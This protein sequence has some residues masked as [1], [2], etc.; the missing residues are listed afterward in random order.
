MLKFCIFYFQMLCIALNTDACVCVCCST[1]TFNPNS[2]IFAFCFKLS[3]FMFIYPCVVIFFPHS[4]PLISLISTLTNAYLTLVNIGTCVCVCACEYWRECVRVCLY[5]YACE[6]VWRAP[7]CTHMCACMYVCMC[8]Y[9]F[10]GVPFA[11]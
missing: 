7:A 11:R 3:Q 10:A 2:L 8:V 9:V 5:I 4:Y 6:R 1:S